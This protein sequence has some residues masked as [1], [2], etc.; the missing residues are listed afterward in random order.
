MLKYD[1]NFALLTTT[2]TAD[3]VNYAA[4]ENPAPVKLKAFYITG[5][6]ASLAL[7]EKT[8]QVF[9]GAIV[10]NGY[11]QTEAGGN[12]TAFQVPDDVGLLLRKPE[13]VGR[14]IAG[15]SYRVR[16]QVLRKGPSY[17][18]FHLSWNFKSFPKLIYLQLCYDKQF[19]TLFAFSNGSAK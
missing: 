13:S 9:P 18:T 14:P 7:M 6:K 5:E 1:V 2:L 12:L 8:K 15:I 4:S 3:L 17:V 16:E 10:G 11:G 19:H